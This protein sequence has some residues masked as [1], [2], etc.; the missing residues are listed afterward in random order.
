M[1]IKVESTITLTINGQKYEISRSEAQQI[2][3]ALGNV[4]GNNGLTFAPGVRSPIP[5]VPAGPW[6]DPKWGDLYNHDKIRYGSGFEVTC[7]AK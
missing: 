4:L 6:V 7:E 1:D 5:Q 3:N 2:Y